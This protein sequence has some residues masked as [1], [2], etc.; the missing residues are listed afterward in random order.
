MKRVIF[1]TNFLLIPGQFGLDIISET[2]R[3][4]TETFQYAILDETLK[5]LQHIKE[6]QKGLHRAA[7][8]LAL[9]IIEKNNFV[10]VD[11]KLL[12]K[13]IKTKYVDSL[14][15]SIAKSQPHQTI[16]ATQDRAL[17]KA[18]KFVGIPV[19]V[20]KGENHLFFG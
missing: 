11:T 3:L 7:S 12:Q 5:E 10:V 4:M 19:I 20:M 2:D 6:V 14:L 9:Q 18:L 16:V 8:H 15:L 13:R 1:D 17:K